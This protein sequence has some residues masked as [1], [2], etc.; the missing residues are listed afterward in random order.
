MKKSGDAADVKVLRDFRL[1]VDL[2]VVTV[3][4]AHHQG[5]AGLGMAT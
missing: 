1:D 5:V 2:D 4:V 3:R